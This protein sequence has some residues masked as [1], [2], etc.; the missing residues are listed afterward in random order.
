MGTKFRSIVL[1]ISVVAATL[2][3]VVMPSTSAQASS[4]VQDRIV[5]EV[6]ANW[7]PP[8]GDGSVNTIVQ[9]GNQVVI[10]GTF[11]TVGGS[12]HRYIAAFDAATGAMNTAFTPT[13]NGE[14]KKV[15]PGPV[16][17]TVLVGGAFNTVNGQNRRNIV[18]L[19]LRDGSIN[20]SMS[21]PVFN[22]QI[23]D[24]KVSGNRLYV[25]GLFSTVGGAQH[26][27]LASL[28]A[29]SG[30]L[31]PFVDNQV[32]QN[33]NYYPGCNCAQSGVG[34]SF[35]DVSADGSTL[36]ATGNFK[37]V[38]GFARDQIV[39]IDLSGSS[40]VVRSDWNTNRYTPRCYDWAFDTYMR[41]LAMSPDGSYF[42][43]VATGGPNTNTLC[44]AA[45][46]FDTSARG[47]DVQPAWVDYSGG[48]TFLSVEITGS[49]VYFGG[50]MRWMNNDFGRDSAAAGSVPRPGLGA[51]DP[52]SG[53]P[54]SWNPGRNPRGVGASAI[55]ATPDGL[56]VGSDTE[57]IGNRQY[58]R[59][60]LA[61][62]PLAGGEVPPAGQP[63]SL[64]SDVYLGG[65]SAGAATNVLYRVNAGGPAVGAVDNGPDW[66]ADD[67]ATS[68]YRNSGSNSASY[69]MIP[70]SG[71][72]GVPASTPAGIFSSERWDPAD[73]TEMQWH[74]PV[75]AGQ[76]LEVRL[77]FANR[78]SGTAQA[79][80]RVFDVDIDGVRKLDKYDI[81]ASVGDQTATM[82]S[83]AV[84]S[85]GTVDIG[86]GHVTENPL[87]NG[88][89]IL[90]TDVTPPAAD[91]SG[92][93]RRTF[94][95]TSA[96]Q[97]T[98]V[99]GSGIDWTTVRGAVQVDDTLF[100]G[101]TD[102]KLYRVTFDG[103]TFGTAQ[104][105]D[106][107][108]DPFWCPVAT[109]SGTTVYCG[110]SPDLYGQMSSV[111][112]LAYQQGRL[113]YTLLG[114]T[115]LFYRQFSPESGIIGAQQ[116]QVAGT[117]PAGSPALLISGGQL[118]FADRATGN[119]SRV[120][121][122]QTGISGTPVLVSGPAIDGHD[123]RARAVFMAPGPGT[124]PPNEAPVASFTAS[125]S[126]M[127]CTFDGSASHDPDGTLASY[128]WDFGDGQS[129]AGTGAPGAVEHTFTNS[130]PYA[131]TLT[132]TDVDGATGS[133]QQTVTPQAP[134]VPVAA[135]GISC[136][137]LSCAF[138]DQSTTGAPSIS[139]YDWDFGDGSTHAT[140]KNPSHTYASAGSY[141]VTLTITDSL[142][143]TADVTHQAVVDSG[144][145]PTTP[146]TFI[147][148]NSNN[149]NT[150]K[151]QVTVPN[152]TK[153]GDGLVLT[154]SLNRSDVTPQTP[155]G[156]TLVDQAQTPG[157][158]SWVYRRTAVAA[159][160]G[161]TVTAS[162]NGTYAKTAV[163][164]AVY[165]GAA[166]GNFLSATSETARAGTERI[167]PAATVTTAGSWVVSLWSDKSSATA[168]WTAPGNVTVRDQ[169]YGTGGGRISSLL[170]DSAGPV[171][172]GTYPARTATTDTSGSNAIAWTL[173]VRPAP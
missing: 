102:G 50:H 63:M 141:D 12:A 117:L 158:T 68:A 65:S 46:R 61:F 36:I 2:T 148:A 15:L 113:Y 88:V 49:A 154:L 17:G 56:W 64:P 9:V 91:G 173:V 72:A 146:V 79:G 92:L 24:M 28:D 30:A 59:P 160:A 7:T 77:F 3:A 96:G 55:Y 135:F 81:A 133:A 62:F 67:A 57:W 116:G 22:G 162:Y 153:T 84:T 103:T 75:P 85:D 110:V 123:W 18:L 145:N 35:L 130:T 10:G 144:T 99:S 8:V 21:F 58:R 120:G 90:R 74:F 5:G 169:T 115:G 40:A 14:A 126:G 112:A 100:Y 156:W 37:K 155:D 138:T 23:R 105:I 48:D 142:G 1:A 163:D 101:A 25:G 111:T 95:G 26:A 19:N 104:G 128:A 16:A 129:S 159:D 151:A 165:R 149:G 132:V 32:S 4:T 27:G 78:Y 76:Q 71:M 98:T 53:R 41:G 147:A 139:S 172:P 122:S 66:A 119:L 20:N 43:V 143:R 140:T 171:T 38:D 93:V 131:V 13:L 137:E 42:V 54:L 44:D 168:A 134:A 97:D 31:D 170:A 114:K 152:A 52:V 108:H 87:V 136:T 127:T 118:Y 150:N 60:R 6:P 86:F 69:D 82:K 107:Y 157:M 45:A 29:T 33:H 70:A 106:P 125:C 11:S 94:D 80:Q 124:P 34:V 89:E 167:A 166:S 164:L 83:F 39:N 47:T 109:G 73:A 121:F 161:T 51:L